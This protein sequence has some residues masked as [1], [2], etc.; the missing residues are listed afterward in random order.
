MIKPNRANTHTTNKTEDEWRGETNE[1]EIPIPIFVSSTA[2][3]NRTR[4]W[5]EKNIK[6]ERMDIN[7]NDGGDDGGEQQRMTPKYKPPTGSSIINFNLL[8]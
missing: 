5:K 6:C 2:K 4:E 7:G 8:S 1:S 3:G